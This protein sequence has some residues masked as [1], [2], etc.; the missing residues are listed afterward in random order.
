MVVTCPQC[1]KDTKVTNSRHTD[2]PVKGFDAGQRAIVERLV[3]H[4]T[5]E[6]VVRT[7]TCVACDHKAY[8][9][10]V[11]ADDLEALIKG[12]QTP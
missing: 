5:P 2:S 9:I 12:G 6:W 3:G 7:R 4:Y 10:E 8:S 11:Y 1:M